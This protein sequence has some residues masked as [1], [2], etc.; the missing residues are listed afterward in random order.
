[1]ARFQLIGDGE[2]HTFTIAKLGID[3]PIPDTKTTTG[4]EFLVPPSASGDLE[5]V[6]EFHKVLGMVGTLRVK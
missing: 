2:H 5:L 6:C 3:I 1:M 4:T